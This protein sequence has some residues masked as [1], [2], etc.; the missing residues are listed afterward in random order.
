M[1]LPFTFLILS[2]EYNGMSANLAG[3]LLSI[4][5]AVSIFGR[6]LPGILADRMGRY[7]T[8]VITSFTSTILVLALWIPARGN[9]PYILFA[10]LYGFSSGAFVSLAP[11]L[12]AQIS[13]VRQ[14]GLRTGSMFAVI[15]ISALVGNP[16]GGQLVA[17]E[18]GNYLHT[19]IFCGVMMV[20]GSCVFVVARGSL[21][22]Y[23]IKDKV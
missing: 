17:G 5:N 18:H 3:Y 10:A 13:D 20:V 23:N 12:I 4:L 8:M 19:Q 11:A 9:A 2:A 14:I 22:G 21:K 15:S 16:I 1:F 7:N 6:T